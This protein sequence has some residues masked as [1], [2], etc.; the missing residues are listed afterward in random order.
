MNF[1]PIELFFQRSELLNEIRIDFLK[2]IDAN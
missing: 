2:N 1:T